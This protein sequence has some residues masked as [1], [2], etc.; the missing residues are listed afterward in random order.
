MIARMAKVLIVG[1]SGFLSGTMARE[2]LRQGDEVW[3][4]TRGL[5]PMSQGVHPII[6]DRKDRAGFRAKISN[7]KSEISNLQPQFG[8]LNIQ[9]SD[10][11]FDL[12]IDSIGFNADDARQDVECFAD[13]TRHLV[14][15][16][17]DFVFSPVDR[18]WRVDERYDCFNDT[19]YGSGKRA[20][21]EVLLRSDEPNLAITILRPC[22]IYGP[23]SQLGCLPAHGRDVQLVSRL[24]RGEPLAL[25]GGGHFL[26]QPVFAADL[27]TMAR[28][29]V[30]NT[31][32]DR[33]I[34]MSPG[35]DVV[36][37]WEFYRIIAEVLGVR[38]PI[39]EVPIEPYLAEH[40]EHAS[41]CCHR[42]Y[43]T[44]KARQHGLA[45]PSTT[46]RDGLRRH[47]ESMV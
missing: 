47:V 40:P 16:S 30:G 4:V 31:R 28:S 15:I 25:V 36:A 27:W 21:E 13:V 2:A 1:G 18:P 46:L 6:A 11:P 19:P 9:T 8:D 43:S 7:L 17:T 42:V 33:Q 37:S 38:C 45:V 12:V 24:R 34:Y 26:Q 29:C 10:L 14:F 44:D 20:A 5:R 39:K 22:H 3:C 23:G 35:P 41:F 32:T